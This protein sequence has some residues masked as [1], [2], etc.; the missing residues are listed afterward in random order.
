M[1]NLTR[2]L[3]A[4]DHQDVDTVVQ[5]LKYIIDLEVVLEK[6]NETTNVIA[7]FLVWSCNQ[8]IVHGTIFPE[9]EH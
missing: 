4:L 3:G 8:K 1:A 7:V 9:H 6:V 2:L 5:E